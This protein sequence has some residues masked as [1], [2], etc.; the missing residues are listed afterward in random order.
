[1][2][3]KPSSSLDDLLR[4]GYTMLRGVFDDQQMGSLVEQ[5]AGALV[6]PDE[7]SVLRSRGRTYGA[8][9]L[10]QAFPPVVDL[11]QRPVLRDLLTSVLGGTAG[12]V[13]GLFFDKPPDRSWSLPWH[14]DKTIAVKRNDL[15][16]SQFRNPTFKAG[17]PHVEAPESRLENM[18]TLRIHLDPMTEENGPLS[19]IPGS[20]LATRHGEDAPRSLRGGRRRVGHATAAGSFQQHVAA[21]NESASPYRSPRICR[22]RGV[23]GRI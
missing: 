5:L 2:M 15:P 13:R 3:S 6:N 8:R 4:D 19:V 12:I 14:K 22:F 10:L 20:H 23:A 9:N 7:Q 21:R 16:S 11:V 18:L 17:V 1:M